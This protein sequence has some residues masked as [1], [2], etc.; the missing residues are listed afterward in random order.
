MVGG[1]AVLETLA[2]AGVVLTLEGGQLKSRA[3]KGAMTPEL[4]ATIR[5]HKADVL[6]H[7]YA[8]QDFAPLPEPLARMV[9][10]AAGGHL[11]QV[12]QLEGGLVPDLGEHV[13]AWAATYATGGD[14]EHVFFRLWTAYEAWQRTG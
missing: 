9:R 13:L 5:R 2:N 4:A 6:A 10:A 11:R 8:R 3:P 1:G 7:L 14:V 12:T